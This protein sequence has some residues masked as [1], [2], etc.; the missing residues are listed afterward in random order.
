M[1]ASNFKL[2]PLAVGAMTAALS[3]G[4]AGNAQAEAYAISYNHIFDLQVTPSGFPPLVTF[5]FPNTVASN[6]A[7]TLT[8]FS[9]CAN[10]A[11]GALADAAK[12]GL[13]ATAMA[14]NNFAAQGNNVGQTYSRSD[15]QVITEQTNAVTFAKAVNIAE[16]RIEGTGLATANS[17]IASDTVFSTLF[18]VGGPNAVLTFDFKAD[19]YMQVVLLSSGVPP[20]VAR[21]A[22]DA[23]ITIQN[24]GTGATVFNWVPDGGILGTACGVGGGTIAGGCETLDPVSLNQ[25][26]V[27]NFANNGTTTY[28]NGTVGNVGS[29]ATAGTYRAFTNALATGDYILTLRFGQRTEIQRVPEPATLALLGMGLLGLGLARRRKQA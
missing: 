15:S 18:A 8:G 19:P 4:L 11:G 29:P 14:E 25:Q 17:S 20:S 16:S 5:T 24:S 28:D 9:S 21:A 13:G 26:I 6:T 1:K 7:A 22:L 12:C 10:G 23:S 27:R 3:L 2:A